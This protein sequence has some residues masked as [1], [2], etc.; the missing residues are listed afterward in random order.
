M[1]KKDNFLWDFQ[2]LGID[3]YLLVLQ[4]PAKGK[5][6]DVIFNQSLKALDKAGVVSKGIE[7]RDS[8]D[9]FPGY[10]NFLHTKSKKFLK[11]VMKDL[12]KD[13]IIISTTKV[14]KATFN[15]VKND[16][17]ITIQIRGIYVDKR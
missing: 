13:K 17:I 2:A 15:R 16:W 3:E 5:M 10:L 9:V 7:K 12:E 8:F 1:F 11:P 4:I 6:F 14:S